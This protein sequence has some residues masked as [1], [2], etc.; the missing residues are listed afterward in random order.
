[1][2]HPAIHITVVCGPPDW[3]KSRL[4]LRVFPTRRERRA[5]WPSTRSHGRQKT[6][7]GLQSSLNESASKSTMHDLENWI[8]KW[9]AGPPPVCSLG[10]GYHHLCVKKL[11]NAIPHPNVALT[12]T[13]TLTLVYA[14]KTSNKSFGWTHFRKR[15]AAIVLNCRWACRSHKFVTYSVTQPWR[16][17]AIK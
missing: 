13:L 8:D 4:F 10:P 12:T 17:H 11:A 16:H 3:S 1:M 9:G 6:H 5:Y 2:N 15:P 14:I 7:Q